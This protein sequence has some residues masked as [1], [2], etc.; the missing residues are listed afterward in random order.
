MINSGQNTNSFEF[1]GIPAPWCLSHFGSFDCVKENTRKNSFEKI[2]LGAT[3]ELFRTLTPLRACR[4]LNEY[5]GLKIVD[6]GSENG[7]EWLIKKAWTQDHVYMCIKKNICLL[8]SSDRG[9]K[10]CP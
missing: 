3:V 8:S 9:F 10:T 2:N 4:N 5:P 6:V 7:S 1:F